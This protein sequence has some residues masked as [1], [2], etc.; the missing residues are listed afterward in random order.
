[1][2]S[3][4]LTLKNRYFYHYLDTTIVPFFNPS[5]KLNLLEKIYFRTISLN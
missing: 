4:K 3:S 1:M 5:V 2:Y